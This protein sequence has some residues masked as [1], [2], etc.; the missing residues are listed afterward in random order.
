MSTTLSTPAQRHEPEVEWQLSS[1]PTGRTVVSVWR[2]RGVDHLVPQLRAGQIRQ[3][4]IRVDCSF[5]ELVA[6]V[7]MSGHAVTTT[8]PAGVA[9]AAL[10]GF[11]QAGFDDVLATANATRAILG[12][13]RVL[14]SQRD[15][16]TAVWPN[17]HH[18]EQCRAT[19][20]ALIDTA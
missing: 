13:E 11:D 9:H 7:G 16:H 15:R 5:E 2:T 8:D 19:A 6:A 10:A 18:Y 4:T 20:T 17:R 1:S 12:G 3:C 14:R